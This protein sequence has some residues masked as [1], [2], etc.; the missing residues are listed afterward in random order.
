MTGGPSRR[1]SGVP[2]SVGELQGKPVF[3]DED[4]EFTTKTIK[5]KITQPLFSNLPSCILNSLVIKVTFIYLQYLLFITV[6]YLFL[7]KFYGLQAHFY[8]T[9]ISQANFFVSV[10]HNSILAECVLNN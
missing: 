3:K 1:A 2:D 5:Y 9:L 6:I 4:Q 7:I 8:K 10:S